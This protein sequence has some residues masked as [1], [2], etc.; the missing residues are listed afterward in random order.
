MKESFCKH[1]HKSTSDSGS[2]GD[3]SEVEAKSSKKAKRVADDIAPA[4]VE[5]TP[6]QPPPSAKKARLS[7]ASDGSASEGKVKGKAA[8]NVMDPNLRRTARVKSLL[9]IG[10]TRHVCSILGPL[11]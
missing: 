2:V 1:Y 7:S 10:T 8:R 11:F 3:F 9:P 6:Q 4:L 5:D